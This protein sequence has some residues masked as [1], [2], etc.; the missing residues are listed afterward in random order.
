VHT[1]GPFLYRQNRDL[2]GLELGV[3]KK[4]K[5]KDTS[6]IRKERPWNMVP[7]WVQTEKVSKGLSGEGWASDMEQT[8]LTCKCSFS[9]S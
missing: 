9:V 5:A 6:D 8:G 2:K 3:G 7:G 1:Y 4:K